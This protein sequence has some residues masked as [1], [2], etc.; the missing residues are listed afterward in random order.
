LVLVIF[1]HGDICMSQFP[2]FADFRTARLA[3][4]PLVMDDAP[5]LT[6]ISNVREVSQWLVFMEGGFPLE[7]AQA[8]ISAQKDLKEVFFAVRLPTGAM[9]GALGMVNH[10]NQTIEIGYW[11]G[12]DHQGK[13]Y[14]YEAVLGLLDQIASSSD[15]ASRQIIAEARPDNAPSI[16]LLMKAGFRPTGRPGHRANRVEFTLNRTPA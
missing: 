11:F 15:L 6:A 9:G 3:M 4:R 8:L 1:L 13:G 14:A 10:P 5:E 12:V 16:K 2:G 7:K